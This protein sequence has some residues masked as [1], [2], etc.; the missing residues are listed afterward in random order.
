MSRTNDRYVSHPF[1]LKLH[2]M[3]EYCKDNNMQHVAAWQPDGTSFAVHDPEAFTSEVIHRF[4]RQS[5]FKSF[6]RQLHIYGFKRVRKGVNKG[7]YFHRLFLRGARDMARH[8]IRQPMDETRKS[9]SRSKPKTSTGNI[10]N[11][12]PLATMLEPALDDVSI[13]SAPMLSFLEPHH[14]EFSRELLESETP[15]DCIKSFEKSDL[16]SFEFFSTMHNKAD[17]LTPVDP[18]QLFGDE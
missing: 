17:L 18:L 2:D 13:F 14:F 4:F 15:T 8:M 16:E 3:L 11:L 12:T 6:Q 7:G 9:K 5:H 1:P 10:S